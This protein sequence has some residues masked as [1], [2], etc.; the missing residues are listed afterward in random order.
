MQFIVKKVRD[1]EVNYPVYDKKT[2]P[3]F[4]HQKLNHLLTLQFNPWITQS[5]EYREYFS[6]PYRIA[7]EQGFLRELP[8][9]FLR[10]KKGSYETETQ[11]IE[12]LK[13]YHSRS[14]CPSGLLE[15]IRERGLQ[16]LLNERFPTHATQDRALCLLGSCQL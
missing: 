7:Q 14:T 2:Y 4:W 15:V 8:L 10:A 6:K 1:R 16:H 5:S 3:P 11:I 13:Q 9:I 12:A